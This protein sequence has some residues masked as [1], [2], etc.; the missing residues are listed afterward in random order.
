[1]QDSW[2]FSPLVQPSAAKQPESQKL[3][4]QNNSTTELDTPAAQSSVFQQAQNPVDDDASAFLYRTVEMDT[5]DLDFTVDELMNDVLGSA[6]RDMP[7]GSGL[8]S[9]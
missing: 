3:R 2:S 5:Q 1:V 7:K 6:K 8:F 9:Q 4:G